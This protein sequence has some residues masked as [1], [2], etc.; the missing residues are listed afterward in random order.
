MQVAARA[1]QK[2]AMGEDIIAMTLGQPAITA[3]NAAMKVAHAAMD[4]P[5][6][7]VD[8]GYTDAK[9]IAPLQLRLAQLYQDRYGI[10]VNPSNIVVT[11]GSSAG[12]VLSLLAMFE[13][14]DRIAIPSPGY[15]AYRNIIRAL[16][17]EPVL[18]ETGPSSDWMINAEVLERSH[19][20]STLN[21]ILFA[22]PNN[23]NGSMLSRADFF[24]LVDKA[25]ELGIKFISDEIYH[26]LVYAKSQASVLEHTKNAIVVNSFSKYYCMTG[27]R[28][29]WLVV[30]DSLASRIEALQQSLFIC[31]PAISQIVALAALD[32]TDELETIK[33]GYLNNR[34]LFED[35]LPK[36][37]VGQIQPMDG[38]FYAYADI[39]EFGM[40]SLDISQRWLEEAHVAVTPGIDFDPD[41][42]DAW[43]RFSFAGAHDRL[44]EGFDRLDQW[45]AKFRA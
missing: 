6:Q 12:F 22:N 36:L 4:N 28:I 37:G 32:A 41:H 13:A 26:G 2:Q 42:G 19:R 17:M 18:V 7:P 8:L 10:A 24:E 1:N 3:P 45:V 25:S 43:M 11:T 29:G 30:P 39:S 33:Q 5:G 15:P 16:G 35:R 9:G 44:K 40:S 21:G 38:A 31:A 23:P 14:G 20:Q 34:A 27:W